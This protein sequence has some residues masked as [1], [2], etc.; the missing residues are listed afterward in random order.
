MIYF[1]NLWKILSSLE[2]HLSQEARCSNCPTSPTCPF[3]VSRPWQTRHTKAMGGTPVVLTTRTGYTVCFVCPILYKCPCLHS[4]SVHGRV[5]ACAFSSWTA[6]WKRRS[7]VDMWAFHC[8]P[9]TP[10]ETGQSFFFPF[11]FSLVVWHKPQCSSH[12]TTCKNGFKCITKATIKMLFKV[13][14]NHHQDS[15]LM[16]LQLMSWVFFNP[17]SEETVGLPRERMESR[18]FIVAHCCAEAE[19]NDGGSTVQFIYSCYFLSKRTQTYW[20]VLHMMDENESLNNRLY[21]RTVW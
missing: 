4:C 2:L 16:P 11:W 17:Y 8:K 9:C 15:Q 6:C 18:L 1:L 3:T 13:L 10:K 7:C 20:L 21:G 12:S 19:A 5:C 14:Q